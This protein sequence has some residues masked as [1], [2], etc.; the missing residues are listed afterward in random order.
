MHFRKRLLT[1][2]AGLVVY[3]LAGS[4]CV[5]SQSED[6][7]AH[8]YSVTTEFRY[9]APKAASEQVAEEATNAPA[10]YRLPP[11]YVREKELRLRETELL[12]D[13]GKLLYAKKRFL[14]PVYQKVFGPI[15]QLA[16]YYFNFLNILGGWH[17]NDA[18]AMALLQDEERKER[19]QEAAALSRLERIGNAVNGGEATQAKSQSFQDRY[20]LRDYKKDP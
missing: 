10:P 15:S 5:F 11:Y 20:K 6:P 17:P 12:T 16:S 18:E 7:K 3:G 19:I 4:Q 8:R 1:T 2:T 9:E 13:R 14:S